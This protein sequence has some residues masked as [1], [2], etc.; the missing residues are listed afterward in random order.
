MW[1]DCGGPQPNL[2]QRM[3]LGGAA[4]RPG[5]RWGSRLRA[6]SHVPA[7][8]TP[9]TCLQNTDLERSGK[10]G[11]VCVCLAQDCS[12]VCIYCVYKAQ[13]CSYLLSDRLLPWHASIQVHPR[14]C[15]LRS[16]KMGC[17]QSP[18]ARSWA[19]PQPC[20][21]HPQLQSAVLVKTEGA[22]SYSAGSWQQSKTDIEV[23]TA[24]GV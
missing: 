19:L 14:A 20:P 15:M 17:V 18:R 24:F 6:G 16:K 21:G 1:S 2:R 22:V 7:A 5:L 4:A 10:V 3:A 11:S 9:N 13:T 8:L 12:R 23:H